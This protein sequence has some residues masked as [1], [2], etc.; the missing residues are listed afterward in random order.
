VGSTFRGSLLGARPLSFAR[1]ASRRGAGYV[2]QI[3][4][5]YLVDAGWFFFAAWSVV[6]GIVSVAAFGR[7]FFPSRTHVGAAQKARST[8]APP[9]QSNLSSF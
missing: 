3:N 4:D 8:K 9:A 1:A 5:S 7:D 2:I 6:V